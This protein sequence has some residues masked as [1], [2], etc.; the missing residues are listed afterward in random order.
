M[1]ART[2]RLCTQA[3]RAAQKT[4]PPSFH[5]IAMLASWPA[6]ARTCVLRRSH[7]VPCGHHLTN[8]LGFVGGSPASALDIPLPTAGALRVAEAIED[9]DDGMLCPAMQCNPCLSSAQ[10]SHDSCCDCTRW[11]AKPYSNSYR[12]QKNE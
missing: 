2:L 10:S 5:P 8:H 3:A 7:P 6:T 4:R 1:R 11:L 12:P 9:L